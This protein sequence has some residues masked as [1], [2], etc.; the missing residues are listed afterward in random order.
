MI[1]SIMARK[2]SLMKMLLVW[3]L[4]LIW[5]HSTCCTTGD[6]GIVPDNTPFNIAFLFSGEKTENL[7]A[8]PW[9]FE[10]IT[11]EEIRGSN[12]AFRDYFSNDLSSELTAYPQIDSIYRIEYTDTYNY[13]TGLGQYDPDHRWYPQEG[14]NVSKFDPYYCLVKLYFDMNQTWDNQL[15]HDIELLLLNKWYVEQVMIIPDARVPRATP[16]GTE[17]FYGMMLLL[18]TGIAQY[19]RK[20]RKESILVYSFDD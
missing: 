1:P 17:H 7:T 16:F 10:N 19:Q 15:A 20:R 3:I 12:E 14:V 9:I 2:L 13:F 8:C 18:L 5:S 6:T 4:I 11:T